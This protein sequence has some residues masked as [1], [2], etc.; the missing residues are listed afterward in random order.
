MQQFDAT[1]FAG[2]R[3]CVLLLLLYDTGLRVSEALSVQVN[4]DLAQ[5]HVTVLGKGN[6]E[7]LVGLAPKLRGQLRP[8]LRRREAALKE[9]EREDCFWLFPNQYGDRLGKRTFQDTLRKAGEAAG[10]EG[11]RVSPHT[12]R[13]AYALNWL[14][15]GGDPLRLQHVLGHSD[16]AMTRRYCEQAARE[17]M[18]EMRELSPLAGLEIES[19]AR[20]R[21][22]RAGEGE[23]RENE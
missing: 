21:M 19:V 7:R 5:G 16:L 10:I 14:R 9:I 12:I 18:D 13:H 22:R 3:D 11:V 6:K 1:S 15:E 23:G 2:H 20:R 4:E 17:V 8:Y